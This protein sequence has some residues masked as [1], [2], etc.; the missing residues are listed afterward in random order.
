MARAH[1]FFH[2]TFTNNY[3]W[4]RELIHHTVHLWSMAH[5]H[6][7]TRQ[8]IIYA[9]VSLPL[10][11]FDLLF[12]LNSPMFIFILH[13]HI[14]LNI[15]PQI[16][17]F[18]LFYLW[19]SKFF[20]NIFQV[21]QSVPYSNSY[22]KYNT[23]KTLFFQLTIKLTQKKSLFTLISRDPKVLSHL[24]ALCRANFLYIQCIP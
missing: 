5:V 17:L 1:T 13:I 3:G 2:L 21:S 10:M 7:Y 8:S 9:T 4:L 24:E 11:Y 22:K 20:N 14:F 19:E 15:G 23:K 18:I 12:C 16:Y 6:S